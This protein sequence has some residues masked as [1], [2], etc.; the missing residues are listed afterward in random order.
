M[1]GEYPVTTP[2][3]L[4]M[5]ATA[6]SDVAQLPPGVISASVVLRPTQTVVVPVM[7]AGNGYTLKESVAE[8]P[9]LTV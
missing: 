3:E 8:Q 7:D 9:S 4:P 5:P 6:R 2:D 1:P